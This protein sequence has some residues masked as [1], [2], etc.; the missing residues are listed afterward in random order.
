MITINDNNYNN[1]NNTE[2]NNNGYGGGNNGNGGNDANNGN[3]E[4]NKNNNDSGMDEQEE[5]TMEATAGIMETVE[6]PI[7]ENKYH[8]S[9]LKS[10]C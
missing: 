9:A 1:N 4:N 10:D 6:P 2:N 8:G 3:N 5:I 7:M